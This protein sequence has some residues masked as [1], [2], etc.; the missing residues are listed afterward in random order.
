MDLTISKTSNSSGFQI[1]R[2]V[3]GS[4]TY[5]FRN[6][7]LFELV[8]FNPTTQAHTYAGPSLFNKSEIK[9]MA[10]GKI[11]ITYYDQT[12]YPGI[13]K[14]H[15]FGQPGENHEADLR[16]EVF[17]RVNNH[18]LRS[19]DFPR[20]SMNNFTSTG[21]NNV[22][23]I[24]RPSSDGSMLMNPGANTNAYNI[25]YPGGWAAQT[26]TFFNPV[27]EQIFYLQ[28]TDTTPYTKEL[29]WQGLGTGTFFTTRFY[30]PDGTDP[31]KDCKLP[32]SVRIKGLTG[33]LYDSAMKYRSWVTGNNPWWL[34]RGSVYGSDSNNHSEI[35]KRQ[36]LG[37]L[38]NRILD[39][40]KDGHTWMYQSLENLL[41]FLNVSRDEQGSVWY[42]W[43]ASLYADVASWPQFP[44]LTGRLGYTYDFVEAV[45][46]AQA[47]GYTVA[48]YTLPTAWDNDDGDDYINE[49]PYHSFIHKS[50]YN[51]G[52]TYEEYFN[53]QGEFL[54]T[55]YTNTENPYF[56]EMIRKEYGNL[57]GRT[58][59][60]GVYLDT[61]FIES[62]YDYNRY[63]I[64]RGPS[65]T[66]HRNT[67]RLWQDVKNDNWDSG[68]S[69]VY[70]EYSSETNIPVL[71]TQ[72]IILFGDT[73][74]GRATPYYS[75]I[76]GDYQ[77]HGCLY[78]FEREQDMGNAFL[79]G[80]IPSMLMLSANNPPVIANVTPQPNQDFIGYLTII[81]A[82]LGTIQNFSTFRNVVDPYI[83][84]GQK[85]RAPSGS[86]TYSGYRQ[87]TLYYGDTLN[88]MAWQ[89]PTGSIAVIMS[90]GSIS[91][92]KSATIDL[93]GN[94]Y[95]FTPNH[96][97]N[98]WVFTGNT[99]PATGYGWN[100]SGTYTGGYTGYYTVPPLGLTVLEF[101]P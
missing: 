100:N 49:Y 91:A 65:P 47:S 61:Y 71:D 48:P 83:M 55:E 66:L 101:R 60:S 72:T 29:V 94:K 70:G 19:I 5:N 3:D 87:N 58:T 69:A 51:T 21:A 77:R 8:I 16:I 88:Y 24:P 12:T 11:R 14:V 37:Y 86:Y 54:L 90:N 34:E 89:S 13:I 27:N 42:D 26:I 15:I 76:Y 40:G 46:G 32:Y 18:I 41:P 17:F 1:T 92:S 85:L 7:H 39:A 82:M 95:P 68:Q 10:D 35:V 23:A 97:Y 79:Q 78:S 6:N 75:Y 52:L 96:G 44:L 45:R 28:A 80:Y 53:S 63:A 20:F 57:L 98:L 93:P 36:R 64:N 50:Y 9:Q 59:A 81:S 30:T 99:Y 4:F 43:W 74:T 84:S 62:P 22:L 31:L 67:A 2:M 56:K 33:D 25:T 38:Q 73:L